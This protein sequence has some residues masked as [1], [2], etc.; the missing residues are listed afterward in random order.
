MSPD[1]KPKQVY[2]VY[3]EEI[4]G[5]NLLYRLGAHKAIHLNDTATLIWKLSDGSRTVAEIIDVLSGEFPDSADAI[6]ND[7][8]ETI[9]RLIQ[10][11][12]LI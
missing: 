12:A 8:H 10:E 4:E 3:V 5:E 6:S 11:G 7:V 9:D 2:G 1:T